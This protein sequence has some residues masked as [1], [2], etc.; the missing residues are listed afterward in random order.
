MSFS[1]F[2]N[3]HLSFV[4]AIL[5]KKRIYMHKPYHTIAYVKINSCAATGRRMG[6][7]NF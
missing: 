7:R 3:C 5:S 4:I 2:A 6:Q 1:F